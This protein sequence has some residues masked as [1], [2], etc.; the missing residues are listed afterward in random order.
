MYFKCI[1]LHPACWSRPMNK[2]IKNTSKCILNIFGCKSLHSKMQ[3]RFKCIL[4]ASSDIA[5]YI[6]LQE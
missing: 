1:L 2:Y 4:N 3:L 5:Y 6:S